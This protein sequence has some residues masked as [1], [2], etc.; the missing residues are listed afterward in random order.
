MEKD[1]KPRDI[2]TRAAFENAMV[3][4]MALGGS[5][6]AVLHLIAMARA[7]DV[8]LT[9]DDF[10]SVSDRIPY[11]ADLKPSGKYV[12][13]DLHRVGGVPAVMRY[14]LSEDLID[15]DCLICTGR[16]IAENL[17]D[18]APFV[19]GQR[20]VHPVDAPIKETGHIRILRGNLAPG[21]T[22]TKITGKA[23]DDLGAAPDHHLFDVAAHPHLAMSAGDR[24]GVVVGLEAHQRLRAHLSDVPDGTPVCHRNSPPPRVT[25]TDDA[26]NSVPDHPP[27]GFDTE[28]GT[29]I[30]S[31]RHGPKNPGPPCR[32][33]RAAKPV[34]LRPGSPAELSERPYP[35]AATTWDSRGPGVRHQ[36]HL[37]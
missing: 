14:L 35:V 19:E 7:V 30:Q 11:I 9:V 15:G 17:D 6:N 18:A 13:E 33:A 10:Q 5:T 37:L 24:D 31:V 25:D 23:G 36:L 32:I 28:I 2:M 26:S 34:I 8:N 21:G 4:V 1:I 20:I 29:R 3:M 27:E 12:M 16:T 22:V